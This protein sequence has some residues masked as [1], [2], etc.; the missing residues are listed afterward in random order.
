MNS[1][2]FKEFSDVHHGFYKWRA[3]SLNNYLDYQTE[4]LDENFHFQKFDLVYITWTFSNIYCFSFYINTTGGIS[5]Q[6]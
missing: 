3:S 2:C 4:L 1:E 5:V 6:W